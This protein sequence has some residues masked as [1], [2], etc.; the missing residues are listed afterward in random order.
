M[1]DFGFFIKKTQPCKN[2]LINKQVVEQI[3]IMYNHEETFAFMCDKE[4]MWI[5]M[6]H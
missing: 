2:F 4:K 5:L 3:E 1:A 6:Q